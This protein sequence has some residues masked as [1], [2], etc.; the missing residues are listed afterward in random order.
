MTE[1]LLAGIPNEGEPLEGEEKE[2]PKESQPEKTSEETPSQEGEKEPK[3]ESKEEVKEESKE[4]ENTPDET[5][6]QNRKTQERFESLLQD[7]RD[8]REERN[9]D[10]NDFEEFK[11]EATPKLNQ[12]EEKQSAPKWLTDAYGD[13]PD[14]INEFNTWDKNREE[15]IRDRIFKESEQVYKQEQDQEQARNQWTQDQLKGLKDSGKQFDD[16]EL[17]ATVVEYRPVNQEGNLDFSKA[18]EILEL[19]KQQGL[20][21]TKVVTEAKKKIASQTMEGSSSEEAP[22]GYATPKDV[23][24]KSWSDLAV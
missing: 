10:R 1:E 7:N 13:N 19:K 12:V 16:N 24:N 18:Y 21:K 6:S 8:L 15:Q 20:E 5:I 23:R 2:T 9:K 11:K 4:P 3:E 14:V 17:L 22:K